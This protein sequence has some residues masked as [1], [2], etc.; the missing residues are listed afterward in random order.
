MNA[1]LNIKT[2]MLPAFFGIFC[3]LALAPAVGCS[4]TK[5]QAAPAGE[6]APS[7]GEQAPQ[8]LGPF[9]APEGKLSCTA[10]ADCPEGLACVGNV[11]QGDPCAEAAAQGLC[12]D[13]KVCR[14]SCEIQTDA[15]E[16]VTCPSGQSCF[17]GTCIPGCFPPSRCVG[18]RC[19]ADEYCDP[20]KAACA[21]LQPCSA[22]CPSGRACNLACVTPPPADPCTGVTCASNEI[23]VGGGCVTN[24][25]ANVTCAA[26]ELCVN[27]SCI[28][29]CNCPN[30]TGGNASCQLGV[31]QCTPACDGKAC[32][33]DNG[34]GGDCNAPCGAGQICAAGP[35]GS[36]SCVC[37]PSCV[38][39]ACG[40]DDGCGGKCS[41]S[42]PTGQT[43]NNSKVCVC[44]PN[45]SGKICGADNGCGSPCPGS[46]SGK[47]CG[48][49]NGCG[50]GVKCS[51]SCP[52]GQTC[53][54][55]R[56]C[57]CAP[58]CTNKQCNESNGCGGLCPANC[59][60]KTCG[61]DN[62]CGNGGVCGGSSRPCPDTNRQQCNNSGVCVCKAYCAPGVACGSSD[63][64]G[65]LCAGSCPTGFGCSAQKTCV[66]NSCSPACGPGQ[67][68][69]AGTCVD[70]C[71]PDRAC[72]AVCC[73]A[74]RVCL[75]PASG[76]CSGLI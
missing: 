22:K 24:L 35:G 33:A 17:G 31:C 30:C 12:V 71:P 5:K 53:N 55:S 69:V 41:G 28:N 62:G 23:C 2:M 40:A 64:C 43:C 70:T 27:G 11:C 42:C 39:K 57:V 58:N 74:G 14:A 36:R 68:C 7:T 45:C 72:G 34:C 54:S 75:N 4:S 56:V 49:D 26:G 52:T 10:K 9:F 60:G 16:G 13:P 59:N 76:S 48:A 8:D 63:G 19:A 21:K 65:G 50:T 47:T 15:C 38:G 51:G 29:T 6:A 66:A 32:G 73:P 25:C 37:S 67:A 20:V 44:A 18:V 1:G 61:A 3:T 46:C